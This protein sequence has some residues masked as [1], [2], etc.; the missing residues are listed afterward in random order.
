MTNPVYVAEPVIVPKA[1]YNNPVTF[2]F[3]R[4]QSM[5]RVGFYETIP[6]YFVSDIHFYTCDDA[7]NLTAT[8]G[9]NIILTSST[10]NY[11]VGGS[12]IEGTVTYKWDEVPQPSYTFAYTDNTN[13]K[14]SK[15][16]EQIQ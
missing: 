10:P 5:V 7:G 15:N 1:N 9:N 11:F 16:L 14:K 6:G 8:T 2:H 13:L 4:Q 12:E 3:V